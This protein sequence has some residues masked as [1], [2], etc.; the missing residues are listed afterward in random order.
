MYN[1]FAH[2]FNMSLQQTERSKAASFPFVMGVFDSDMILTT[3]DYWKV[4]VHN[5]V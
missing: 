4:G 1:N 5:I 2:C 3:C